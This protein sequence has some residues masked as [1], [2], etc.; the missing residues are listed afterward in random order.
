MTKSIIY[1]CEQ[2]I[3]DI[4]NDVARRTEG[5]PFLETVTR[6]LKFQNQ[7][8]WITLCSLMDVLG[9]TELAK[10]NFLTYDLSGPT[11]IKDYGEQ[12]LR[13][14]G[15][16]NAIYLQKTA[17]IEFVELIKLGDKK[18]ILKK[19]DSLKILELRHIV[20]AHTVDFLDNG[21]KN[22]HQFQRGSLDNNRP[23]ATS[24]AKGNYKEYDLK[25]L[26][27]EYD[28]FAETLLIA[29]TDKFIKTVYKN[30]GDKLIK[31]KERFKAIED[32]KAGHIVVYSQDGSTPITIMVVR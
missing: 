2:L 24:D 3:R 18:S 13:L 1:R 22:P 30:G 5:K 14:Y 32:Q 4:A 17:L 26:L 10:E 7:D 21:K 6:R 20:G 12:Y 15:I 27:H 28:K 16:L 8:D 11:K 19:I 29:A 23:I 9:D 25:K 31:Y